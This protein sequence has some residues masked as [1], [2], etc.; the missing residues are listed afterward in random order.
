MFAHTYAYLCTFNTPGKYLLED[1]TKFLN[2]TIDCGIY[3]HVQFCH[4]T[5]LYNSKGMYLTSV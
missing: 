3:I 5:T 4:L 2:P 1:E